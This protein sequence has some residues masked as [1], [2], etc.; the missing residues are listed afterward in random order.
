MLQMSLNLPE[1]HS[2]FK[3]NAAHALPDGAVYVFREMI[4]VIAGQ[5]SARE[6]YEHFKRYFAGAAG[7]NYVPSSDEGWASTDLLSDMQAASTYAPLFLSALYDAIESLRVGGIYDLPDVDDINDR[8]REA[9]VGFEIHPPNIEPSH[10]VVLGMLSDLTNAAGSVGKYLKVLNQRDA[11]NQPPEDVR[12][13]PDCFDVAITV[14]GPERSLA[15]ALAQRLTEVG[16]VVFYDELYPEHLWG[17]NL[18]DMFDQIFRK[19]SRFCVMFVSKAYAASEW[20]NHER[21]SALARALR[22]RG[23]AY[24][25]PIR[26]DDTDLSGLPSTIGYVSINVGVDE[27]AKRLIKKVRH[28]QKRG[29]VFC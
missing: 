15:R 1:G 16:I 6:V 11:Q 12:P 2:R 23:D 10:Q 8:C 17:A 14:A 24:I 9:R 27:I 5:G 20:T 22:E 3:R 13:L 26:V 25:L 18:S 4:N 28:A 29:G 21:K 19:T 7:Q